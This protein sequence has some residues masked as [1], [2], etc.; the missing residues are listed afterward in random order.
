MPQRVSLLIPH[1]AGEMLA[2]KAQAKQTRCSFWTG[3]RRGHGPFMVR[4]PQQQG[5]PSQP[6][7]PQTTAE[8]VTS[9]SVVPWGSWRNPLQLAYAHALR[10][11]ITFVALSAHGGRTPSAVAPVT[12]AAG[13]LAE[14]S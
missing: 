13:T 10:S 6:L 8:Q 9:L 5:V 4:C 2:V 3:Q 11:H 7:I 14:A 12:H 1:M